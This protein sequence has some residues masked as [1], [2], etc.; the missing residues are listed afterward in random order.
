MKGLNE[1]FDAI[2]LFIAESIVDKMKELPEMTVDEGAPGKYSAFFNPGIKTTVTVTDDG[3]DISSTTCQCGKRNCIHVAIMI[4]MLR[5]G[6]Y[7]N[8]EENTAGK[9][10]MDKSTYQGL[11][12]WESGTY[13]FN[14]P[15]ILMDLPF[16]E[17][18]WNDA[19]KSLKYS[20]FEMTTGVSNGCIKVGLKGLWINTV[21][22]FNRRG[23]V[24]CNC[25]C[26]GDWCEHLTLCCAGAVRY[27][28]TNNPDPNED[29]D[30]RA[31]L[32]ENTGDTE[33]NVDP[34]LEIKP[35]IYSADSFLMDDGPTSEK[36]KLRIG[37]VR[38]GKGYVIKD[39]RLMCD[40][41]EAGKEYQLTGKRVIDF[42]SESL[43]ES[44]QELLRYVKSEMN[45]NNYLA[46]YGKSDYKELLMSPA[47]Y[48]GVLGKVKEIK[49]DDMEYG[50]DD[51]EF[52][53]QFTCV[54]NEKRK[55]FDLHYSVPEVSD[56][57]IIEGSAALYFVSLRERMVHRCRMTDEQKKMC[58][59]LRN[60]DADVDEDDMENPALF[61][62]DSLRPQLISFMDSIEEQGLTVD[63]REVV[64]N[65]EVDES[66]PH[67]TY[68]FDA[69]EDSFTCKVT[70]TYGKGRENR[71][72]LNKYD[73]VRGT[74]R[75]GRNGAAE[76][77]ALDPLVGDFTTYDDTKDE[78]I[79]ERN[80]DTAERIFDQII[81][82][83]EKYGEV[84]GTKKFQNSRIYRRPKF[85]VGLSSDNGL[86]NFEVTSS[87]FTPEELSEI[88][89]TYKP[90]K[91]FYTLK[92]G[93]MLDLGDG[94]PTL[95][96]LLKTM[97]M[98]G[99][100]PEEFVNGRT[101]LPLYRA[102]YLE[103]T[104]QRRER[105]NVSSDEQVRRFIEHFENFNET[106]L[107]LPTGLNATLRSYQEEGY[108]WMASLAGGG[109][110]GILADEMGLGK[111]LQTIAF[112]L[113]AKDGDISQVKSGPALIVMPAALL[114][115]WENEISRFAQ[116]LRILVV[117]GTKAQR[118]SLISTVPEYDVV[119]TT[120]DLLKRDVEE[121]AGMHFTYEIIDEAQNIKNGSTLAAKAV[122]VIDAETRFALTG[123]PIENRLS[124]LWSI[125][126]Y[127]MPGYLF[128]Y[129]D[130][131]E[132][133]ERPV[134]IDGDVNA[135]K[136][137][138]KMITPFVLRRQKSQVLKELPEKIER[139]YYAEMSKK[140]AGLYEAMANKLRTRL[141]NASDDEFRH[142]KIEI[143]AELTKIRQL[144]C[145]PG[146][147][148]DDFKGE[149]A[150]TETCMELVESA[151]DGGHRV[152]IFS[153]FT[154]MLEILEKRLKKKDFEY[155]KITG[156]TPKKE[157][158]DMVGDFNGSDV[159]VF[160]VS[161]KAGGTGLNLT[162]ADVVIHYDPWWNAAA[163]NQATDRAHR[164]GQKRNVL[165]YK[166]IVKDTIEEKILKVQEKKA[167][168]ADDI[169]S[170]EG[171]Q[172]GQ[173]TRD[174][175]MDLL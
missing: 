22:R 58:L 158:F 96:E 68:Y 142:S 76:R 3:N 102:L 38:S 29:A 135:R 45:E 24:D 2:T 93:K 149:S 39:V 50:V 13:H 100:T 67:M 81:P 170:G 154:S 82:R 119:L 59:M 66:Q 83:L 41:I 151:I 164:I 139:P 14:M 89:R 10:N 33:K 70:S 87:D 114:Y 165:V 136:T 43:S 98:A 109:F 57:D 63:G 53:P 48:D 174:D 175:L 118:R 159:P 25:Y 62:S 88:L 121:Y 8:L 75:K 155:Y 124:E 19:V 86:L 144:C 18:D 168:L 148:Y 115:N 125:F 117:N 15:K 99:V 72:R 113:A 40:A 73:V 80:K 92:T 85:S 36:L 49:I 44:D 26:G 97:S 133:F 74:N 31:F 137:L 77:S 35:E 17:A 54:R 95:D 61:V 42:G 116:D 20:P 163:Q 52:D 141:S 107:P 140:Q 51:M 111:T 157:R 32:I 120:Y 90:K 130:F 143:L 103:A 23:L 162:G 132:Q 94:D 21:C 129:Q 28:L 153:Q 167:R 65:A 147:L 34:T 64:D 146:L 101:G 56:Y 46:D 30:A 152:I 69:D 60:R 145:D 131:R 173:I 171:M 161:L 172:S 169:L 27:V 55:G 9:G 37:K 112:L 138:V 16:S 11:S 47:R 160:L 128:G 106:D 12:D 105:L 4:I 5:N 150:K 6:G 78:F 122:K 84:K 108:R 126:D 110:G 79:A 127:V 166:L 134:V 71:I 123:T 156:D 7:L 1:R 104:L 91:K